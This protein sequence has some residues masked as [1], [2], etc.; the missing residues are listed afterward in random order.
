MQVEPAGRIIN[1]MNKHAAT[2]GDIRCL[3]N[4]GQRM[5]E[6]CFPKSVSMLAFVHCQASQQN[7]S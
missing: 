7:H 4:S 1:R 6:E 5:A 3:S 2:S